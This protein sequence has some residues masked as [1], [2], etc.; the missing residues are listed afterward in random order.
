M[1]RHF[2]MAFDDIRRTGLTYNS[3][4]GEAV[5]P[6]AGIGNAGNKIMLK[7]PWADDNN[8]VN[9]WLLKHGGGHYWNVNENGLNLILQN[10]IANPGVGPMVTIPVE[11]LVRRYPEATEFE[12]AARALNQYPPAADNTKDLILSQLEPAWS[13]R[14]VS[15]SQGEKSPEFARYYM[16]NFAD[17][18]TTFRLQYNRQPTELE[19][20]KLQDKANKETHLDLTLMA[21]SNVAAITP[22]KPMSK[23]AVVQNGL[24]K[25]YEQ[26]RTEGHDMEWL[27]STF[28]QQ[29]GDAY[30]AMIYS[31]GENPAHLTGSTAEVSA[32]K[33]HSY[34]AKHIDPS[35]LR[36]AIGPEVSESDKAQQLYSSAAASWLG[37]QETGTPGENFRGAKDPR[38]VAQSLV[39]SQGWDMYDQMVNALDVVAEQK[40]LSGYEA[41]PQLVKAK[42]AGLEYIKAQN[43]VFAHSYDSYTQKSFDRLVD[44]MRLIVSSPG[45]SKD[46]TRSDV[47]WLGQYI[48]MRDAIQGMLKQRAAGGGDKT[49]AAKGNADLAKAFS[50]G[51]S[52]INQQSPYFKQYAY[53]GVIENDPLLVA[54]AQ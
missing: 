6:G 30:M 8:A 10:G 22:A 53:T 35:L 9:K 21:L 12:K 28:R 4:T 40:G 48:Q 43:P 49:I 52:Y 24:Q 34:L 38:T 19:L 50:A 41:D 45:L 15:L 54:G 3:D 32:I 42:Q 31:M 29:Y 14:L 46:P 2:Q 47:Y 16:S 13:R 18:L 7:L 44:D 23:Y 36:M 33:K 1:A 20:K 11:D 5:A 26:M 37:S 39:V 17:N 27:R 51:V 25:L